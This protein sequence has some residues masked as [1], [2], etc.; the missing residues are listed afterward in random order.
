MQSILAGLE[1]RVEFGTR[2]KLAYPGQ[3]GRQDRAER[4][5]AGR[6]HPWFAGF[7]PSAPLKPYAW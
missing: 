1:T 5:A 2:N 3:G 6:F 4:S 7:L